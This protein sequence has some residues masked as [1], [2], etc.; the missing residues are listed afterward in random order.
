VLSTGKSILRMGSNMHDMGKLNQEKRSSWRS[1]KELSIV[2]KN[3]W[4]EPDVVR[5]AFEHN[6]GARPTSEE[7]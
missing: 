7:S 6:E 4:R 5:I 2:N 1:K 3:Q